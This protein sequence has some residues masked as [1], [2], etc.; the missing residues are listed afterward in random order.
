MEAD[1]GVAASFRHLKR[2]PREIEAVKFVAER[3]L[4]DPDAAARKLVEIANSVETIQ[5]SRCHKMS[6]AR[7]NC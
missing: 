2:R 7:Q 1:A 3:P 6:F 5:D 4:A